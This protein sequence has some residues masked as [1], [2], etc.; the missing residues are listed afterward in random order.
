[1]LNTE[2]NAFCQTEEQKNLDLYPVD[3]RQ[4][5]DALNEW[6]YRYVGSDSLKKN[7]KENFFDNFFDNFFFKQ[8]FFW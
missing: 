7:F 4:E 6:I 8:N 3:L 2:F 5:I 1:M